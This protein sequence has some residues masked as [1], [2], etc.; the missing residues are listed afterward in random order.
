MKLQKID[1]S[2]L[3][4][5]EHFQ[6]NTEFRDLVNAVSPAT[7]K[8]AVQFDLYQSLY[9]QED[10]ALKKIM[11]SAITADMQNAD[12]RRDLTF[13]GMVDAN[14][15]ALNHFNVEVQAAAK[16]LKIVFD[17]YGNVGLKPLNEETSAIYNLLQELQGTH[18]ADMAIVKIADWADELEINNKAF[19]KLVKN[20]YDE[21]AGRTELVLRQTR[22]QVDAAYRTIIERID[23]LGLIEDNDVYRNFIR[24]LNVVIEKYDNTVTQRKGIASAKARK[25]EGTN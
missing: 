7:L 15:S 17:T 1:L 12:Q 6:F 2:R 10:E 23:A 4:N 20:R 16:R 25:I 9:V 13:R 19:E 3:R 22:K 21:S 24:K 5:D 11:K 14:K 18:A 8:V